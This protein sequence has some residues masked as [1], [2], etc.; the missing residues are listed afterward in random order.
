M[1]K[2]CSDSHESLQPT[3]EIVENSKAHSSPFSNVVQAMSLPADWGAPPVLDDS[4]PRSEVKEAGQLPSAVSHIPCR[5]EGVCAGRGCEERAGGPH[6]QA[7]SSP[8]FQAT[9]GPL[10]TQEGPGRT[11][12]FLRITAPRLPYYSQTSLLAASGWTR[13]SLPGDPRP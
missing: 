3:S 12:S 8:S 7:A 6:A 5:L 1:D 9:P 11:Q 10:W 4:R 2:L 13:D